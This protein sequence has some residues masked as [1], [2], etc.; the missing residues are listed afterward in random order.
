MPLTRHIQSGFSLIEVLVALLVLSLGLLG[1]AGLQMQ[2]TRY[3]YDSHLS[4]VALIQAQDMADR[5]RAN[6]PGVKDGNYSNINNTPADPGCI[7]SAAGCTPTQLANFDAFV[8]NTD[9]AVL[10]PSGS[11]QVSC[12]D[13]VPATV[14]DMETGSVCIVTVRW[15]GNRSGATGLNCDPNNSNDLKCVRLRMVP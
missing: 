11:G 15:D 5:M 2:G 6:L 9:N 1:I 14:P 3:V 4:S 12:T 7:G 8:W 10:L 13:I